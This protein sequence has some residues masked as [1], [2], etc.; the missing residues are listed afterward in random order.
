MTNLK[1]VVINNS[2]T[3]KAEMQVNSFSGNNHRVY[4]YGRDCGSGNDVGDQ[5]ILNGGGLFGSSTDWLNPGSSGIYNGIGEYWYAY[6]PGGSE[7][8]SAIVLDPAGNSF[9]GRAQRFHNGS[10]TYLTYEFSTPLEVYT[11][12][13][14]K[15]KYR[16]YGWVGGLGQFGINFSNINHTGSGYYV[17][18][19]DG[20]AI[21]WE[22]W[23][24]ST[25]SIY[26]IDFSCNAAP[27][28]YLEIDEVT[29]Y[30]SE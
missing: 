13:H 30:K 12:Y 11:C 14:F 15:M 22:C 5:I 3:H 8:F 24:S 17:D 25:D 2:V 10:G 23:F 19:N 1:K 4:L 26:Y 27:T 7:N 28:C 6:R 20:D 16:Y 9:V 18:D 29:L 21:Y